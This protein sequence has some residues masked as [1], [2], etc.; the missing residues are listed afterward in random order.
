[1]LINFP[2]I[3]H[4]LTELYN[5]IALQAEKSFLKTRI[6]KNTSN[7]FSPTMTPNWH[8]KSFS[9]Q[10]NYSFKVLE[11]VLLYLFILFLFFSLL[12]FI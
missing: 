1:M 5:A 3:S 9:H 4:S 8:L 7:F 11:S 10:L 6:K 12:T 2:C